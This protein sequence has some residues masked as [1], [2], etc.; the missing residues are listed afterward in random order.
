MTKREE[1]IAARVAQHRDELT[2][3][4]REFHAHPE[5]SWKESGT[6]EKIMTYLQ[7]LGLTAE[8]AVG[9]GVLSYLRGGK[10]KGV[11]LGM[12]ADMDALPVQEETGLPFASE[13]PGVMH[14][15]GHD[16]HL[17][18]LLVAARVLTELREELPVDILFIFQPAE[19]EIRNSGAERMKDHPLVR[20][21]DR[22]IG[23]HIWGDMEAGTATLESGPVMA[24]SDT[25]RVE[26]R[27]RGGHGAAPQRAIDP[28]PAGCLFVEELQRA[29]AR[30]F[31]PQTAAL[32]GVTSFQA[33]QS[34]NVIPDRA[35]LLGTG[36]SFDTEVRERFPAL[37]QRIARGIGEST[38]TEISVRYE[39]G[40]PPLINDAAC[41]ETARRAA[42]SIFG[43]RL[44]SGGVRMSGEDFAKY[45]NPKCFLAL[46]GGSED[47]EKRYPNHSPRFQIEE[48][49]LASGVRFFVNYAFC[50]G[51]EL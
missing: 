34:A 18:M 9:T 28:I 22:L 7:A 24:A 37:L 1:E 11:L 48:S 13:V 10:S 29:L 36:R 26:I 5:I 3:L 25:F 14:A 30:E 2:A 31:D 33:G 6:Q 50:Y 46:G 35:V 45:E 19:E 15:C 38:G 42:A 8:R 23:L 17:A 39:P 44:R 12:R 21:C 16:S 49:A 4:R 20:R 41:T 32:L 27:G 47:A 51:E 40:P 43:D